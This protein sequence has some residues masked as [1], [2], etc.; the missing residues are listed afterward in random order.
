MVKRLSTIVIVVLLLAGLVPATQAAIPSIK[1]LSGSF[2]VAYS[3]YET[4]PMIVGLADS[5]GLFGSDPVYLAP[6]QQQTVGKTSGGAAG[7][8]YSLDLPAKPAPR[9]LDI[10]GD[11]VKDPGV[12]LFDIPLMSDVAQR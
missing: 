10:N 11:G 1:A 3:G 7:G 5:S 9:P 12:G 4:I 8:Q 6:P 2:S